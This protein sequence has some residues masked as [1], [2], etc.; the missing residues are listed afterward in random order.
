MILSLKNKPFF[1]FDLDD[2][3]Y[4]EIE[5]LESAYK[6]IAREIMPYTKSDVYE[7][8]LRRYY[9]KENVF[10]WI[11]STYSMKNNKISHS[12]LLQ[13]YRNH[14]PEIQLPIQTSNFL[15]KLKERNIPVGLITDGRSI[16]QR[17]KLKS[18]GLD[19]YFQDVIISEEFGSEKPHP[20]NYLFFED[21]YPGYEFCYVADN[22][23]KDF[24]VPKQ[25]GWKI[26]CLKDRGFNIHK[27][28]LEGFEIS[29]IIDSFQEIE[30]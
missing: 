28:N 9:S 12:H 25:L 15:M 19:D 29:E 21:K 2:T 17:N 5:F 30:L 10:E 1:V 20:K 11:V 6:F 14:L 18:L 8:M 26:Y 7:E 13:L 27:Q 24:V 4:P 22:T 16:T 3:L 23:N